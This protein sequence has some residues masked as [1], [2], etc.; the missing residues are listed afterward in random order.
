VIILDIALPRLDGYR[1][2]EQLRQDANLQTVCLI[3]LSG[4][5]SQADR[6]AA[7]RAGFDYHF[8]KPV[9]PSKLLATVSQCGGRLPESK[10]ASP[11]PLGP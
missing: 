1:V 8:L 9:E 5:G 7:R 11:L 2:A 4:Y 6:E 3:A 10:P